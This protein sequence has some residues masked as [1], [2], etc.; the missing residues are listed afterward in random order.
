LSGCAGKEKNLSHIG[1]KPCLSDTESVVLTG[2][3]TYT[4]YISQIKFLEFLIANSSN[5]VTQTLGHIKVDMNKLQMITYKNGKE[6]GS[7]LA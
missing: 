7:L 2:S 6:S 4:E 5:C 1:I 3:Y